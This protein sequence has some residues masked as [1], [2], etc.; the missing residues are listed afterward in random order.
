M[1]GPVVG[2]FESIRSSAMVLPCLTP[3]KATM[4]KP[5]SSMPHGRRLR[6][7][8]FARYIRSVKNDRIAIWRRRIGA[9]TTSLG[10][11]LLVG[12][13]FVYLRYTSDDSKLHVQERLHYARTLGLIWSVSRYGSVLLLLLSLFG[14]GWSRSVGLIVNGGAFFFAVATLGVLC[15]PYGCV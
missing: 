12:A 13:C 6:V 3:E 2:Q 9:V 11:L 5:L 4:R 15:G 7:P 10:F 1:S 14:L 8:R